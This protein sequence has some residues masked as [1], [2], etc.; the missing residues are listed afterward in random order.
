[1]AEW[2]FL[3]VGKKAT[4]KVGMACLVR[5]VWRADRL[6]EPDEQSRHAEAWR[7]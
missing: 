6:H 3:S 5:L 7:E 1:M 2:V 4:A